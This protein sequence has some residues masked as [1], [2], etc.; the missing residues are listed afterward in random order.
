MHKVK[1][2]K[3]LESQKKE[4]AQ[5]LESSKAISDVKLLLAG[6]E[7]EDLRI[8]QSVGSKS[9]VMRAQQE[10]GNLIALEKLDKEY[11]GNVYTVDAI[12]KLCIK[13]RLRFLSSRLYCGDM[14]IE[15]AAKIKEFAKATNTNIDDWTLQTRF[16]IM[17]PPS[18]FKLTKVKFEKTPRPV[19][20]LI[21]YK[22]SDDNYKLI[23]KW[24]NDFSILRALLGFRWESL[25]NYWLTNLFLLL[26]VATLL[27]AM[28]LPAAGM[29]SYPVLS[30]IAIMLTSALGAL[31]FNHNVTDKN[32]FDEGRGW[33]SH[34]SWNSQIL[35]V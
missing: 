12:Q 30:S 2:E 9:T 29:L 14:D 25:E 5:G 8:M 19:D 17:A 13:Y 26:P 10:R 20:P 11:A 7:Q 1:I 18:S 33:F 22:I 15:V 6:E 27:W 4:Q 21:F 23:H 24:G 16:F 28:V 32:W 34:D 3:E 31:F 35:N